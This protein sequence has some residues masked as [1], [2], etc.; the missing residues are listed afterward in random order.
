MMRCDSRKRWRLFSGYCCCVS[1]P[2]VAQQELQQVLVLEDDVRFEPRFCSRLVTL[3]EDVQ[4]V[5]LE[6][7]LMLVNYCSF[8]LIFHHFAY[9]R[10]AYKV[11]FHSKHHTP[12]THFSVL[13][14]LCRP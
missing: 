9:S 3:M 12:V 6:W 8:C 14:K 2:K 10:N 13:I 4:R 11:L 5:G 7:D 1:P